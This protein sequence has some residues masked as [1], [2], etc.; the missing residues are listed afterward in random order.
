[1]GKEN[2]KPSIRVPDQMK[3][4]AKLIKNKEK[5]KPR[6]C[7]N[8]GVIGYVK[9]QYAEPIVATSTTNSAKSVKDM[10]NVFK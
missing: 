7:G 8:Y 6:K 9:T 3:P 10:I 4:N 1:M 2:N 5:A